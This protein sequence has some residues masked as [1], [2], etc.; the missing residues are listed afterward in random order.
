MSKKFDNKGIALF[1][2][3][4]LMILLSI[5]VITVFL[6]V[7]NY[8]NISENQIKRARAL[9]VAES[10][11]SYAYLQLWRDPGYTGGPIYPDPAGPRVDI[12][13]TGPVSGTYTI[14]STVTY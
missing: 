8:A 12:T 7:Y 10:G 1:V 13:V 4:A 9:S 6:T 14:Q 11:I 5:G 2:A 3:L